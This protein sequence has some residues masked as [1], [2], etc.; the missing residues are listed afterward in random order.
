VSVY[1]LGDWKKNKEEELRARIEPMVAEICREYN[2][3]P[4]SLAMISAVYKH[5]NSIM[6]SEREF[7]D[8]PEIR[9]ERYAMCGNRESFYADNDYASTLI[10]EASSGLEDVLSYLH[11]HCP[12]LMAKWRERKERKCDTEK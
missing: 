12:L 6:R 10:S 8:N 3:K 9:A 7:R 5:Y 11:K 2:V 1:T 4:N